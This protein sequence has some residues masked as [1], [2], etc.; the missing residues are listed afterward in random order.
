MCPHS[1]ASTAIETCRY[2]KF[3]YDV[4]VLLPARPSVRSE[5]GG[6]GGGGGEG[7]LRPAP[8]AS[9]RKIDLLR[10]KQ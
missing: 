1:A 6:A 2:E 9:W 10:G 8:R 7:S 5:S 3:D 4:S